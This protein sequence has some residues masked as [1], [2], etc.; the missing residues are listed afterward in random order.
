VDAAVVFVTA[1]YIVSCGLA[2]SDSHGNGLSMIG[3]R[4]HRS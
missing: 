1:A 4:K 3:D 2:K